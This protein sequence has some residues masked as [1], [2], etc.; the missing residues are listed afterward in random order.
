MAVGTWELHGPLL[1]LPIRCSYSHA[2]F[3]LYCLAF[4]MIYV[5]FSTNFPIDSCLCFYVYFF[6][7]VKNPLQKK[8]NASTQAIFFQLIFLAE[9]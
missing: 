2:K 3:S 9:L 7:S 6:T 1:C 5:Y 8:K 4:A